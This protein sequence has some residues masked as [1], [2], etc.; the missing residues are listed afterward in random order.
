MSGKQ[1][2]KSKDINEMIRDYAIGIGIATAVTG[3]P[4]TGAIGGTLG[5]AAVRRLLEAKK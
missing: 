5:T 1:D 4:V 3:N 2:K